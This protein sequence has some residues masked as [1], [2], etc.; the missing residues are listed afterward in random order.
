[1]LKAY[2]GTRSEFPK[3]IALTADWGSVVAGFQ[4]GSSASDYDGFV[5]RLD[6][7]GNL[8]WAYSYGGSLIDS[9]RSVSVLDDGSVIF[10]GEFAT[11]GSS[12]MVM[13]RV[14]GITGSL[15]RV[16]SY[17]SVTYGYNVIAISKVNM[18]LIGTAVTNRGQQGVVMVVTL[19]GAVTWARAHP[20]DVSTSY[21]YFGG[22]N[23][24]AGDIVV[25]GEAV[26]ADKSMGVVTRIASN[27]DHIFSKKFGVCGFD[28]IFSVASHRD[29]GF[30]VA[31]VSRDF[32][33]QDSILVSKFDAMGDIVWSICID[34]SKA[35]SPRRI[36][37]THDEGVVI[38]GSTTSFG[39]G[40]I[41][42]CIIKLDKAGRLMWAKGYG[43]TALTKDAAVDVVE[44]PGVGY[45]IIGDGNSFR[46]N[47]NTDAFA[48]QIDLDGSLNGH[49][50]IVDISSVFT[51]RNVVLSLTSV[52]SQLIEIDV[53]ASDITATVTAQK[54]TP[55]A[56]VFV[57]EQ[58][59]GNYFM[60]SSYPSHQPTRSPT[61]QPSFGVRTIAPSSSS[62]SSS[63]PSEA[64][65]SSEPSNNPSTQAPTSPSLMPTLAP[66]FTL[67][68]PTPRPSY[69]PTA[70]PSSAPS[71]KPTRAPSQSPTAKPSQL[72]STRPTLIPTPAP[73][74]RPTRAPSQPPTLHPTQP[75]TTAPTI[76]PSR[77]PTASPSQSPIHLPP[78]AQPTAPS[79]HSQR[80]ATKSSAVSTT[81][82][83]GLVAIIL[84]L[85]TCTCT[86]GWRSLGRWYYKD[87]EMG[88]VEVVAYL[89]DPYA[90]S[91]KDSRAAVGPIDSDSVVFVSVSGGQEKPSTDS[92]PSD[93][94]Q[95]NRRNSYKQKPVV[96]VAVDGTNASH[97]PVPHLQS[98]DDTSTHISMDK[99][100]E[101]RKEERKLEV[102]GSG[103][104]G[105]ISY[106]FQNEG[107]LHDSV[108][109]LSLGQNDCSQ[110][111][112]ERERGVPDVPGDEGV[113]EMEDD[114]DDDDED[115]SDDAAVMAEYMQG[116]F[117]NKMFGKRNTDSDFLWGDSS[118]EDGDLLAHEDGDLNAA[119]A[120]RSSDSA[121]CAWVDVLGFEAK[122]PTSSNEEEVL[123]TRAERNRT[124]SSM[125]SSDSDS[126]SD[127]HLNRM[128]DISSSDSDDDA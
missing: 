101:E 27:G 104:S 86:L 15:V 68:A 6:K 126:D 107:S 50:A 124:R 42:G 94:K 119:T 1:M 67:N 114:D 25:V 72:P 128:Y 83:M 41:K 96:F 105:D 121:D 74:S 3:S 30:L 56:Y 7:C 112:V 87:S 13:G 43:G 111:E 115:D 122:L 57:G 35:D 99:E 125:S 81:K 12:V 123:M 65:S 80:Q 92:T 46:A 100:C 113:A 55:M 76:R 33:V 5:W 91:S 79:M 10:S 117:T 28:R 88:F 24:A 9:L 85:A 59:C 108:V 66:T 90:G 52:T 34:G 82:G 47:A 78:T 11:A 31:G 89:C 36:I 102:A 2:G 73:S 106:L 127:M 20:A 22:T 29:G 118:E 53:A 64:P 21:S 71:K 4:I 98:V 70:F 26:S 97:T 38:V 75:P 17:P 44:L 45:R 69:R 62:P 8:M 14:N 103:D 61:P 95:S 49:P 120:S 84:V 51:V 77:V 18:V 39:P 109:T 16:V 54:L 19:N 60:Y 58:T 116:V 63:V 40:V 48:V 23:L 37:S 32:S 93:F 110:V